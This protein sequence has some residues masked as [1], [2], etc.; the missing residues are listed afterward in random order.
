MEPIKNPFADLPES[1][2]FHT[3]SH[4]KPGLICFGGDMSPF[5]K[6]GTDLEDLFEPS[7]R[8]QSPVRM[9]SPDDIDF[10]DNR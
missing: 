10:E 9:F 3:K 5:A 1:Y 2:G 4:A 6:D 8:H 7:P